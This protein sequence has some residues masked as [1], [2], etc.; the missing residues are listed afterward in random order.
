MS[1][2]TVEKFPLYIG[3]EFV[4]TATY[5]TVHL[6]YDGTPV[7]EVPHGGAAE[8]ERAVAAARE[9]ARAMAAMPNY[10]RADLLLRIRDLLIRDAEEFTRLICMET[11]KP[12]K[13][14]RVEASRCT[15][16]LVAAAHE[17]RQLHGEVVPMDF[18]AT[19]KGRMAITVREP[20][21]IIGSI[22][23]F[24]VP[25]N[26]ALHKL[27]PALAAGNSMVHKPSEKT[28]LSALRLA[29]TCAEAGVPKG[30]YNVI[31]GDGPA[32]GMAMVRH[33]DIAMITF[34]GSVAIGTS[35]RASAGL[36]KVTL[37]LGN[38]SA[39]ILEPDADLKTAVARTTQGAF[40][41]SGQVCISVQ[42]VYAHESVYSTFVEQLKESTEKLKVGHPFEESTDIS[43]LIDESAAVRVK[44]WIDEAVA[45]GAKL[46]TGGDRKRSTITPAI[47]TDVP[48]EARLSC[49]EVFGPVVAIYPYRNLED[50]IAEVNR[51]PYGLQAGIFTNDIARAFGA[52]RKLQFGGVLINDIPMYRADHMPYGGMKHSGLGREGPKYAIEEMTEAKIICWKV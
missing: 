49:Q 33:E 14:A 44:A 34:T 18:S 35:I 39:V 17:A 25:L 15:E 21:G 32:L 43:S 7:G 6:P 27:A 45:S 23:P 20:L 47:L 12:I 2:T 46:V 4:E 22:T 28:P 3:G 51:T 41:Q 52:A 16:T 10:E 36:K 30:A 24:N 42:R 37:E 29:R 40:G 5:D 38:N 9:G 48:R 50:A 11:G 1:I 13:E 26:L 8:L 19:G 31:T